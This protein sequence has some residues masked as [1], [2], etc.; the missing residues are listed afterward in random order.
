MAFSRGMELSST[1]DKIRFIFQTL[2][3]DGK[4]YSLQEDYR[5]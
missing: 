1:E 3:T 2:D 4:I 5:H